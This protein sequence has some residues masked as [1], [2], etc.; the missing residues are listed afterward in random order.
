MDR[1]RRSRIDASPGQSDALAAPPVLTLTTAWDS[2]LS[3]PTLRLR[4]DP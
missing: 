3:D 1:S 4:F 2:R